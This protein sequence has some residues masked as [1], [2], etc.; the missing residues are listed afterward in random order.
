[1]TISDTKTRALPSGVVSRRDVGCVTA[2]TASLIERIERNSIPEPNSGCWIWLGAASRGNKKRAGYGVMT[3]GRRSWQGKDRIDRAHRVS[4]RVH[5]GEI[6]EGLHVLHS[7]DNTLCVNPDHLTLGT[8]TE[9]VR[10]MIAKGRRV[11]APAVGEASGAA[12]Y[13]VAQIAKVKRLLR[14][15]GYR[16]HGGISRATGVSVPI[17]QAISKGRIWKH[18]SEEAHS[19]APENTQ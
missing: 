18:V 17:I 15:N 14:E 2:R 4:Y 11:I 8:H 1:M 7:C 16:N 10:D 13:T 6:P 9:N 12:K 5:K 3:V 19:Q